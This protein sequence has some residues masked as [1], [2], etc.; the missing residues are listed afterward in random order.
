[1]EAK[2]I[3]KELE[4]SNRIEHLARNS[5]FITLKDYKENFD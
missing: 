1:M 5:A 3:A 4:F 2:H